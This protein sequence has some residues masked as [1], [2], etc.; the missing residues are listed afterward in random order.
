MNWLCYWCRGAV[1]DTTASALQW[2]HRAARVHWRWPVRGPRPLVKTV[3]SEHESAVVPDDVEEHLRGCT[4]DFPDQKQ[5]V[6]QRSVAPPEGC[7]DSTHCCRAPNTGAQT[8]VSHP[9]VTSYNKN[10]QFLAEETWDGPESLAV[11]VYKDEAVGCWVEDH[12]SRH[13]RI[14]RHAR[15]SVADMAT[16]HPRASVGPSRNEALLLHRHLKQTAFL[17]KLVTQ[18][19]EAIAAAAKDAGQQKRVDVL[20]DEVRA[21]VR[22]HPMHT[23]AAGHATRAGSRPAERARCVAV[24]ARERCRQRSEGDRALLAGGAQ[25]ATRAAAEGASAQR[26]SGACTRVSA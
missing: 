2:H 16:N 15:R 6:S 4:D 9:T 20:R 21:A 23:H 14:F 10:A 12:T 7:C 19:E 18:L 22:A 3:L 11:D 17:P 25:A 1:L 5:C 26:P 8:C 13:W 24:Q